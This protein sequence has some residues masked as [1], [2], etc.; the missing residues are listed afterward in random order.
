M[1]GASRLAA[2]RAGNERCLYRRLASASG[3]LS[4]RTEHCQYHEHLIGLP[5]GG[6]NRVQASSQAPR[7]LR[8]GG[9]MSGPF[10]LQTLAG[11]AWLRR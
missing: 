4:R 2:A 9:I 8:I 6:S 1:P 7:T 10:A 11:L 3:L 5:E